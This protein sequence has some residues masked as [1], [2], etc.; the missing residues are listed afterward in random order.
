MDSALDIL[1]NS[2]FLAVA[3]FLLGFCI[4]VHELG[5]F[6]AARWRGLEVTRFSIGFG[7]K[8]FSFTRKGV[9][10]RV[11]WIPLGGYV[12]LPQL[13]DMRAIEGDD[14][15]AEPHKPISYSDKL[16]VLVAGPGFNVL[17]GIFLAV[18]LWIVGRPELSYL[19][20]TQIG[21]VAE[22]V[23]TAEGEMVP[24]PG[25]E[26]GLREG[27]VIL[28]VDGV[29]PDGWNEV[30]ELILMGTGREDGRPMV[31]FDV[32]RDGENLT[33]PVYPVLV[34]R[35]RIRQ[36]GIGAA[37]PLVLGL[38][39]ENSPA[40]EAGLEVG[41]RVVSLN[42]AR[43]FSEV[44][45]YRALEETPGEPV[46]LTVEREGSR[47]D[48]ALTGREV[49]TDQAGN[50]RLDT[51]FRIEREMTFVHENPAEIIWG[52]ILTTYR[53]LRALLSPT[54][55]IRPDQ[56]S[57]PPGIAYTLFRF[58]ENLHFLIWILILIN[59]NLAFLNLLPI[60]VLDG[61]HIV[62]ATIDKIRGKPLPPTVIGGLQSVFMI[63]LLSLMLYVIF[64]DVMRIGHDIEENREMREQA[65]QAV[66]PVF[67][68]GAEPAPEPSE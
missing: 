33:V 46:T 10:Y 29:E 60:P 65:E 55:D 26:A 41:D 51:G 42:G 35:E 54:S 37:E 61:G 47:F 39:L 31:T 48:V 7:P 58:A 50:T 52:Q 25:F 16:W 24:A 27:D 19:D 4:F 2:F 66:A 9:D 23:E 28:R 11:S 1:Q 15:T 43:V 30:R 36:V 17:F 68:E 20:T 5:H 44:E 53:T 49:V 45:I 18:I 59:I 64:H 13:S 22:E 3:I 56:L 38:I 63:L 21:Y 62:F 67:D 12:A 14:E 8:I 32:D 57:G 40:E 6:L 34:S